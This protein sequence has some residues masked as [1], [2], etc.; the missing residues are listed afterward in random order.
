MGT[1]GPQHTSHHQML[2]EGISR[3]SPMTSKGPAMIVIASIALAAYEAYA[4]TTRRK[5]ITDYSH[6]FPQGL[7]IYGWLLWL[8]LHF[9]REAQ[10][11]RY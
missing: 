4:T 2:P 11:S 9:I 3:I 6:T 1:G 8:F 10:K 7:F 5:T